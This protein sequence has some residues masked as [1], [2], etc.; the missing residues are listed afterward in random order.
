M[1]WLI[2]KDFNIDRL[3]N[4]SSTS[5]IKDL[6]ILYQKNTEQIIMI[7]FPVSA[8]LEYVF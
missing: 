5:I 6:G 7:Y 8:L 3:Q 1:K 4:I 2:S